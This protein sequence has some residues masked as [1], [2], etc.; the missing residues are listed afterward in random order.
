M[1]YNQYTAISCLQL[2][3]VY[4]LIYIF[5]SLFFSYFTVQE[6]SAQA[7]PVAAEAAFAALAVVPVRPA[8]EAACLRTVEAPEV[9]AALPTSPRVSMGLLPT[10]PGV[11][12]G[13]AVWLTDSPQAGQKCGKKI[14]VFPHLSLRD[15]L[16][17]RV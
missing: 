2:M 6:P 12:D 15:L 7:A 3:A 8:A 10:M 17:V 4:W 9:R 11:L 5:S 1:W 14:S 16:K 13:V